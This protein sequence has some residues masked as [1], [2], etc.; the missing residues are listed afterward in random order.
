MGQAP[1]RKYKPGKRLEYN[2]AHKAEIA[3][4]AT[5]WRAEHPGRVAELAREWREKNKPYVLEY[6]KACREGLIGDLTEADGPDW[7]TR[8]REKYL[9]KKRESTNRRRRETFLET[10]THYCNGQPPSCYCCGEL[11][12]KLLGLDHINGGGTKQRKE[13]KEANTSRWARKNGY[14]PIFRVAC[15]SCNLGAHLNGGVCP[16]QEKRHAP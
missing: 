14:P 4:N 2:Q 16:H 10:L 5:K 1:D 15:H 8:N 9:A 6:M 3:A 13:T 11:E 7:Q 12:V